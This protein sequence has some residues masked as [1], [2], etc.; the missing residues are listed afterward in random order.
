MSA[1][2]TRARSR[3]RSSAAQ[4]LDWVGLPE[5]QYALAQATVYLATAPKSVRSGAAYFAAVGDVES[6]GS[7]PVPNHLRNAPDRRLKQHG[8]GIGYR[9]PPDYEGSDVDQ[10]YLP[11][12]LPDR[13]YFH[14]L[15]CGLR[16]DDRESHGGPSRGPRRRQPPR[17]AARRP[18][19][20]GSRAATSCGHGKSNRKRLATTQKRDARGLS[21]RG[22]T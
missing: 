21:V 16:G 10:Q 2:P 14:A 6:Q 17:A 5:A 1:T 11:D 20:A 3:S 4:A 12:A 9:Y 18:A 22:A 13:R 15:E 19:R 8:I 7:L